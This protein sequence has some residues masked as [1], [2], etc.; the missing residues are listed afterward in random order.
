MDLIYTDKQ[1]KDIGVMKDYT[2]DLAFG[3]DE[4]DFELTTELE[5]H[6]CEANGLVYIE[7]TEYGGIIDGLGVATS[8]DKLTYK[9]RTWHG[10]LNSKIIEPKDDKSPLKV[11]GEVNHIIGNLIS[12]CG[13]SNLFIASSNNSGLYTDGYSFDKYI[14]MY[15]GLKKLVESVNGKLKFSYTNGKVIVSAVPLIDYSKDEQFDNDQVEMEIDK[16]YNSVNHLICVPK[17]KEKK[18]EDEEPLPI[19]HLYRNRNG[20]FSQT[21][22]FQ[23]LD[24]IMGVYEYSTQDDMDELLKDLKIGNVEKL[25]NHV[26]YDSVQMDFEAEEDSY[27]VGDIIGA[28]EIITGTVASAKITKKIVTIRQGA[29][30]I[31]YKVGE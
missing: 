15:S 2:F 11:S 14:G 17:E 23:G 29:V 28:R 13:L 22:T 18:E 1:R 7:N 24:E 26:K 5:N 16:V 19:V 27:D 10:I 20:V 6:C 31:Q 25:K 3:T 8:D 30:N 12:R 21:Q 4:N 9:G